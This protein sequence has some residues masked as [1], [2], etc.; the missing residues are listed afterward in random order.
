M[1]LPKAKLLGGPL[2]GVELPAGSRP[3]FLHIHGGQDDRNPRCFQLPGDGRHLYRA[4]GTELGFEMFLFAGH[5]H[6]LCDNCGGFNEIGEGERNPRC[7]LCDT[8][9]APGEVAPS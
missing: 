4:Y 1:P 2:D 9:L 5:T 8:S 6:R 3:T 7:Q